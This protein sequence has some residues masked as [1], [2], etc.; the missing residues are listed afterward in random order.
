VIK[1]EEFFGIGLVT[2]LI[3]ASV[4]VLGEGCFAERGSLSSVTFQSESTLS[5][6]EKY[7]FCGIDLVEIVVPA[8]IEVFGR[9]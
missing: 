6:I 5:R 1:S 8:S 4:E 7:A 2:I 3:L 9:W